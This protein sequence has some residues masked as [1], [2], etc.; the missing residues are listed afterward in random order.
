LLVAAPL[1]LIGL[2][3]RRRLDE[4]PV[5]RELDAAGDTEHQTGSQFRHL[6]GY[7]RCLLM[8]V[9]PG[10]GHPRHRGRPGLSQR[11]PAP[12]RRIATILDD[13]QEAVTALG[14]R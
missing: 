5:F 6:L 9:D 1:G 10:P 11:S 2:Y 3:L 13:A 8:G 7:R 12:G 14:G 4:T